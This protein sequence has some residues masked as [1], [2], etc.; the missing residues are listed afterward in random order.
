MSW[1]KITLEFLIIYS[2]AGDL[3]YFYRRSHKLSLSNSF[4]PHIHKE[5]LS[6]F[7]DPGELSRLLHII[8]CKVLTRRKPS[9]ETEKC[10]FKLVVSCL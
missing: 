5:N 8:S 4:Q 9:C 2:F 7:Q 6:H 1:N 10:H 3:R